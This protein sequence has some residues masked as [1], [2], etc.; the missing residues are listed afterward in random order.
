MAISFGLFAVILGFALIV[1]GIVRLAASR[2]YA[3]EMLIASVVLIGAGIFLLHHGEGTGGAKVPVGMTLL[4]VGIVLILIGCW[5]AFWG[6]AASRNSRFGLQF[7][8]YGLIVIVAGIVIIAMPWGVSSYGGRFF[9]WPHGG[10]DL[11]YIL[12]RRMGPIPFGAFVAGTLLLANGLGIKNGLKGSRLLGANLAV[13]ALLII[14]YFMGPTLF[15][16]W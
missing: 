8:F 4:L 9:R 2:R 12:S 14:V 1:L 10:S 11:R 5:T 15:R 13:L 6:P 3:V 16:N 7:I